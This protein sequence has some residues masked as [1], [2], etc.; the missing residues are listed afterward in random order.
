[1][2][3]LEVNTTPS[4][5]V[6]SQPLLPN[7]VNE[8]MKTVNGHTIESMRSSAA[9][10]RSAG[11]ELDRLCAASKELRTLMHSDSIKN[12]RSILKK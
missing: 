6:P 8:P 5:F 2:I 11:N 3:H 4:M 9:F 12:A 7:E 1:M 10:N